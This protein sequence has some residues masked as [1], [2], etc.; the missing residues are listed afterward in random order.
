MAKNERLKTCEIGEGNGG[1][2]KPTA[3]PPSD[4]KGAAGRKPARFF[5]PK[6]E[7]AKQTEHEQRGWIQAGIKHH[8]FF[9]CVDRL[10]VLGTIH[11]HVEMFRAI[12]KEF[13]IC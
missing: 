8:L 10:C 2:A 3:K 4:K 11:V 7:R 1:Q 12:S 9:P 5:Q 6:P 13:G